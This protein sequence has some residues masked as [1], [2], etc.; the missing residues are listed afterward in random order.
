MDEHEGAPSRR[1]RVPKASDILANELRAQIVAGRLLPG[2]P[3]PSESELIELHQFSRGTVREA[4]RLLETEGFISIQRGPNGGITVQH[5][6]VENVSHSLA[7]LLTLAETPLRN[8][9]E[10]RKL[11]EPHAVAVVAE[12]ADAEAK[13]TLRDLTSASSGGRGT[14]QFHQVLAESVPDDLLRVVMCAVTRVTGW[15]AGLEHLTDVHVREAGDMHERIVA[16]V[17]QC[18]PTTASA[19]MLRHLE[20]FESVMAHGGR[21]DEPILPRDRW[22]AYLRKETSS[23]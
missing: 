17:E 7:T 6:D 8:L 15:H 23:R 11:L 21:L 1:L 13:A 3:L 19:L 14:A 4:L 12:G 20:A 22:I 2:S 10:F 18:D 5:P 9:F 16:A